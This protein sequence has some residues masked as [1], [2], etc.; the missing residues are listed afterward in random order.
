MKPAER[1][2]ARLLRAEHG[3]SIKRIAASLDV[4]VSSVS[5]WVS[6]IELT[7]PQLEALAAANPVY[8][9]DRVG[10]R[11]FADACRESR[12]LWQE[13]G[14]ALAR[15]GDPL[16]LVGCMLYWAE[17]SK[18]RNAVHFTNSDADMLAMCRRFLR[19]CYAVAD[20]RIR[21]SVSC[22]LNNGLSLAEI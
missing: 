10:T 8:A 14:R 20:D 9:R 5:R 4:S 12:R 19:G 13:E 16:H 6:D 11:V 7:A 1:A 18:G 15:R 3:W 17:G 22:H 21:L 2:Q